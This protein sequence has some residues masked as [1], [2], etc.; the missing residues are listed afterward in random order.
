MNL[1]MIWNGA[2][3]HTDL[4]SE[5]S[6]CLKEKSSWKALEAEGRL[7]PHQESGWMPILPHCIMRVPKAWKDLILPASSI[8]FHYSI[9]W[10]FCYLTTSSSWPE[11]YSL[12]LFS[13]CREICLDKCRAS[14]FSS[15]R[16]HFRFL[17]FEKKLST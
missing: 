1:W 8:P 4:S 6:I 15:L 13:T 14:S 9:F 7:M 11:T 5:I 10:T 3:A 12:V 16:F 17:N 2:N